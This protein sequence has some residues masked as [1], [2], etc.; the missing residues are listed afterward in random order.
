MNWLFRN[1]VNG[2]FQG[3]VKK[4]Y[5]D[6]I[7]AFLL[8]DVD[9]MNEFMNKIALYSFQVLTLQKVQQVMMRRS[10]FIMALCWD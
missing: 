9:A 8:N 7:K 4:P 10:G 6:F 5:N 2:W 3:S 1:M